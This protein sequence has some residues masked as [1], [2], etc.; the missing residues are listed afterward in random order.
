MPTGSCND[1]KPAIVDPVACDLTVLS[2][3][4][5]KRHG[6]LTRLVLSKRDS[7]KELENGYQLMFKNETDI[8]LKIAEWMALERAC[9]PF[10]S[11]SLEVEGNEMPVRLSL[12]G[13]DGT[14]QILQAALEEVVGK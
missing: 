5:R 4:Q 6:E 8:L 14:K 9:C 13:P 3:D 11:F 1:I 7:V 12:E 2:Q 10:F